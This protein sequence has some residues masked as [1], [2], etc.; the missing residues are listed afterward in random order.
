MLLAQKW[1]RLS[2]K[3][4]EGGLRIV[5]TYSAHNGIVS[6]HTPF[7]GL[8]NERRVCGPTL[9]VRDNTPTCKS[10]C[11]FE[12]EFGKWSI[13]QILGLRSEDIEVRWKMVDSPSEIS[14]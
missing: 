5:C 2:K 10:N 7:T 4:S 13:F 11:S 3:Y 9:C 6:A 12:S 14:I 1:G 8:S